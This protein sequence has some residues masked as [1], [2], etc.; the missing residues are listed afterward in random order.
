MC[1]SFRFLHSVFS[2][3]KKCTLIV[4][5]VLSLVINAKYY[6][7]DNAVKIVNPKKASIAERKLFARRVYQDRLRY[8]EEFCKN[9]QIGKLLCCFTH[10]LLTSQV[11]QLATV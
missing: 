10:F 11:S 2:D 3:F 8:I 1:F 6:L 7:L 4:F 9:N 5:I